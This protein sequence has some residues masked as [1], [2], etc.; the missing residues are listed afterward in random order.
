[1]R[2]EPWLSFG[3]DTSAPIRPAAAAAW[4]RAGVC[5]SRRPGAA[6]PAPGTVAL[7][8]LP[9]QLPDVAWPTQAVADRTAARGGRRRPALEQLL[10]VIGQEHAL[11]GETRAVVIV[12]AA[13]WCWSGTRPGYGPDTPLISWSMAKSITQA[14]VGVAVEQGK[15]D[16]DKPMGNPHWAA[17]DQR[18]QI[19]GGTW[20]N[21]TDGQRYLEIEAKTVADSDASR[22]LFGPGRLD[23]ANYCA[24]LPLIHEPGTHWN[25]N[26]CGI[27]TLRP[28]R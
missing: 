20:L 10:A 12:R 14:L 1:M 17:G 6:A 19:P 8:P 18:A 9:A 28:M 22:K 25:Y 15:V 5:W 2:A 27:V 13:G 24:G 3:D 23:V 21:M 16:I 7:T 26:S 11:L 4:R